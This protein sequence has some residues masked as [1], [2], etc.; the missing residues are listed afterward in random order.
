MLPDKVD[1]LVVGGGITGVSL[2][3][4]L[5]RRH[6]RAV[7]VE[8]SRL[9]VGA[10][11]RNAGFLL[12]G[13]AANYAEAVRTFGRQKAREVWALTSENHDLMVEA[14]RGQKVG[15]R[16]LGSA[17]LAAD[18]EELDQLV[19]SAQL[20]ADDGFAARWDGRR[21]IN[22]RDGEVDPVALV[23]ALAR[24]ARP[25]AIREGVEI[26]ALEPRRRDVMVHA[27]DI[28]CEA[29]LVILATNAYTAQLLPSVKIRP[30]RGQMLA[31]APQATTVC[32]LPTYSQH[33]YRYWRQL[34]SG[35]VLLGGWRDT[36]AEREVGYEEAPTTEIQEH[37]DRALSDLRATGEA[38]H[39][40]A[41]I[42]GFTDTG[43]PIAGPVEKMPNVLVCAGYNG[44]GMGFAFVTARELVASL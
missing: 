13:V 19:E 17:T 37:L 20:L 33:G 4:H 32:D 23:A 30:V 26:T 29:G 43:L 27:G 3:H 39:R 14:A 31:A 10:S 9:A 35:E 12:A 5:A 8:R 40:W 11:G 24:Q 36:A 28:S 1:V 41:G 21:L 6:I 7:L 42:M 16:R 15:H 22:P 34:E 18:D 44:H 25:G 38:T 2:L